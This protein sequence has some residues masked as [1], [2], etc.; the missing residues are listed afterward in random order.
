MEMKKILLLT[1]ISFALLGTSCKKGGFC[2]KGKDSVITEVREVK[3]FTSVHS[4]GSFDVFIKQN[5]S[6]EKGE[7]KVEAPSDLLEYIKTDVSNGTLTIENDKCFR[8][9]NNIKIYVSSKEID[10]I[11]LFGSGD[12]ETENKLHTTNM[13]VTLKGAGDIKADVE[14]TSLEVKVKGSGDIKMFGQASKQSLEIKGSGD[15]SNFGLI[16]K[17]ADALVNGSGDIKLYAIESLDATIKGSGDITYR[18]TASVTS[19]VK[20]SGEIH[21]DN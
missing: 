5:K 21:N 7:I 16:C 9:N 6:L 4:E 19:S 2:K 11:S 13:K 3:S 18:G 8:G 20:G 17:V 10:E 1:G 12:I 15:I 14:V